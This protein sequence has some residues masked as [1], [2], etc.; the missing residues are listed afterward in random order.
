MYRQI[1][2]TWMFGQLA[3]KEMVKLLKKTGANG[4]D[5]ALETDGMNDYRTIRSSGY[6]N[7]LTDAGLSVLGTVPL[8]MHQERDL[9]SARPEV[10]ASALAFT[11]NCIDTT[12]DLGCENMLISPSLIGANC[13]LEKD[14]L[15]HWNY[16]VES[17]AQAGEYARTV[18]IRLLLEPV[19]RFRVALVHTVEEGAH[20]I[21]ETGCD[22]I[23][24]VPDIFH[25]HI[26]ERYGVANAIREAGKLI[27][28][29][30]IGDNTRHCPGYGN[31]DWRAIL[32]ALTEIGFE[33][34][35]SYEPVR[36]YFDETRM[37][38][39]TYAREFTRELTEGIRYLEEIMRNLDAQ[40]PC[41]R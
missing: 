17:L 31:M 3:R 37:T 8:Y 32:K 13:A 11:K 26:E 23:Y 12:A 9:S 40:K 33:G 2:H 30:H 14:Y 16:A 6:A 22:N 4:V 28:C 27:K 19:N 10:R 18:G 38:E 5:L 35:L 24:L 20:M 36:L 15:T 41:K 21:R 29:L 34:T 7:M 39:Q 1:I 25:M